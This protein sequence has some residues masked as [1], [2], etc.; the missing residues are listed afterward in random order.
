M[1][2]G[3][4]DLRDPRVTRPDRKR[5]HVHST[6]TR[7]A[8]PHALLRNPFVVFDHAQRLYKHSSGCC[9]VQRATYG[10]SPQEVAHKQ[11]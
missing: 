9:M 10:R 5:S 4:R 1:C 2:T 3:F 11:V 6:Q 7:L 8:F